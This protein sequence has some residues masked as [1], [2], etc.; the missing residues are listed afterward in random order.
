[1][2]RLIYSM[3]TSLD[4]FIERKHSGEARPDDPNLLDWV[5]ID[6]ELHEFANEEARAAGAFLYGRRLYENMASFWPTADT[7][8]DSPGYV[9][10]FA[11]IWKPKPK[12][13][14]SRTIDKV[15]WNSRLIKENVEEEVEKLKHETGDFLTVGG[16]NFAATLLAAGL[17]DEIRAIVHPVVIGGGTPFLPPVDNTI[18]LR[19]LETETFASGVVFVRYE[20]T[21]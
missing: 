17:I 8:P 19:L 16:A 21:K 12:I 7:L 10:D 15:E 3:M 20:V 4:G 9:F 2:R 14:F 5:I 18:N 1:M 6:Q 11:R 13:V